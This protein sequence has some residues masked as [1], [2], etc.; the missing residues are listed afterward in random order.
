MAD[1]GRESNSSVQ[2]S[3]YDESQPQ[4]KYLPA[5][6]F[7]TCRESL[8]QIA[9][10]INPKARNQSRMLI[11]SMVIL[12]VIVVVLAILGLDSY[13]IL[14]HMDDQ[15]SVLVTCTEQMKH[16]MTDELLALVNGGNRV[17][18]N[19]YLVCTLSVKLGMNPTLGSLLGVDLG[20]GAST[21]NP[22]CPVYGECQ[23]RFD[24]ARTIWYNENMNT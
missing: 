11:I 24:T 6:G 14:S 8:A 7:Q 17:D 23:A 20:L 16:I 13:L 1:K 4:P 3:D 18:H 12:F 19:A 2:L 10:G 5:G 9:L 21:T 15:M 22:C